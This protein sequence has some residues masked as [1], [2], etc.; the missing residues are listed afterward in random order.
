MFVLPFRFHRGF[1]TLPKGLPQ[2][3]LA[4]EGT[5]KI[6]IAGTAGN[7]DFYGKGTPFLCLLFRLS[8]IS[9]TTEIYFL[10]KMANSMT[11]RKVS[12]K[13]DGKQKIVNHEDISHFDIFDFI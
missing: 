5:S 8:L 2:Q 10:P 4:C 7:R 12:E 1:G 3:A 13:N 9:I 11:V 6:S